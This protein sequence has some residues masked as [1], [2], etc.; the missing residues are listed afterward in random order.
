[1]K[2]ELERSEWGGK[3]AYREEDRK[4]L[5]FHYHEQQG[6]PVTP[7]GGSLWFS[8]GGPRASKYANDLV[9]MPYFQGSI[10]KLYKGHVYSIQIPVMDPEEIKAREVK[11]K[12]KVSQL[13]K[14]FSKFYAETIDE[15]EKG[16][17]YLEDINSKK[18][19]LSLK[20]LLDALREADGILRRAWELHM[21]AVYIVTA[22]LF[23]FDGLCKQYGVDVTNVPKLLQGFPTKMTE[24]DGWMYRLS[25]LALDFGFHDTFAGTENIQALPDELS[26]TDNGRKWFE[27][28]NKFLAVFGKRQ[29]APA[30]YD[31]CYATWLEDPLSALAT[32]KGY[33]LS[34]KFDFEAQQRKIVEKREDFIKETLGRIKTEEERQKFQEA[35]KAAQDIYPFF[36]DHPFYVEQRLYAEIRYLLLECGR[37]FVKY[38]MIDDPS[39][40]NFLKFE[41]LERQLE[42]LIFSESVASWEGRFYLPPLVRER[43]QAWKDLHG[44]KCPR[45]LGTIPPGVKFEDPLLIKFWGITDEVV[46]GTIEAPKA[47]DKIGGYAG[48]PGVVEGYARVVRSEADYQKVMAGDIMVSP[49]TTP[50]WSPLFTKVKAVVTDGGGPLCHAAICAREYGIPAVV[51]TFSQGLKATETIKTGQKIRVD[52]TKGLVEILTE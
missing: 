27:E 40:V 16:L 44:A 50:T 38:G 45:F 19:A 36:E 12:E 3:W 6:L 28:F 11:Y 1:M 34:G 41:E 13:V 20:E 4:L 51:G 25:N 49:F 31:F 43:K 33:I 32:I 23:P 29:T 42:E 2:E 47:K 37:R 22:G 30:N 35:L 21:V 24:C 17:K 48:A 39:D 5:A 18:E 46:H 7:M 52:G 26:K 10:N 14:N 15:W 8:S 9:S